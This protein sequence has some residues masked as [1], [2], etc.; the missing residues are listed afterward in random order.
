MASRSARTGL[1]IVVNLLIVWA[2]LLCVRLVA[3]FT[4]QFAASG[5]GGAVIGLTNYL[6]I[7]F[8]FTPIKTPYGG[9]FS[10]NAAVTIAIVLVAEW[11][12]S[13]MRDRS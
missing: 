7:P 10:V 1:T 6:V 3:L 13:G 5:W 8:G 11:F 9:V 2:V 4:A 12:L